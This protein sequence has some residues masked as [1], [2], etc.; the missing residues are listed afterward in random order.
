LSQS[1]VSSLFPFIPTMT[2]TQSKRVLLVLSSA[3]PAMQDGKKSGYYWSETY[4]PYEEFTKAGY[5]VDFVSLTGTASPDEHSI[6]IS[7]QLVSF[8]LAAMKAWHD[9]SHQIHADIKNLKS[10]SQVN[11][12]DYGI[13]FFAGG[14]ACVWDLPSATPIHELASKIYEAGGVVSAVCHGPAVFGG[15]KLTNGQFLINN[16][17]C[18]GFTVEEE[19]KVGALEFLRQ[20]NIPMTP[21]L[22]TQAGGK[23]EKSGPMKDFVVDDSRVVSGQNPVSA[24]STAQRAIAVYEGKPVPPSH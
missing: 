1:S 17:R 9:S 3:T 22:I 23:Y 7:T 16:K 8:E 2:T 14:H 12:A 6:M 10:P 11:P 5:K 13:I 4:Y 18:A 19:E 15:L 24:A 21:D 20:H